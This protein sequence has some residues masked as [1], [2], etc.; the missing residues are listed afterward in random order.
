MSFKFSD[1]IV[2]VYVISLKRTILP[3]HF[4]HLDLS[5]LAIFDDEFKVR[6]FTP[7]NFLRSHINFS[8]LDPCISNIKKEL[9]NHMIHYKEEIS[10]LFLFIGKYIWKHLSSKRLSS[11]IPWISVLHKNSTT[12]FAP[13]YATVYFRNVTHKVS[14]LLQ[15]NLKRA[16]LNRR[17]NIMVTIKHLNIYPFKMHL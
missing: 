8:W 5:N 11:R 1:N 15:T 9:F 12:K 10:L 17:S 3:A 13:F 6:I 7:C 16:S 14:S 2:R 4:K